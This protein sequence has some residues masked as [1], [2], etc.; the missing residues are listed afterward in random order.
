VCGYFV[1]VK[2]SL[3]RSHKLMGSIEDPFK[4]ETL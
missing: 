2:S 1:R 3:G 4:Y